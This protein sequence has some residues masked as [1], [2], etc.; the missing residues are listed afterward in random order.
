MCH[1][2][3]MQNSSESPRF[4]GLHLEGKVYHGWFWFAVLLHK[5]VFGFSYGFHIV[6]SSLDCH[7]FYQRIMLELTCLKFSMLWNKIDHQIWDK[8]SVW[9]SRVCTKF[10]PSL[11]R[12]DKK[13]IYTRFTFSKIALSIYFMYFFKACKPRLNSLLARKP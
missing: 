10:D 1:K 5:S 2:R 9:I 11:H 6:K 7:E 12:L 8:T 4:W 3:I 13:K